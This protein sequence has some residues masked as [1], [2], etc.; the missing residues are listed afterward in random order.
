MPSPYGVG[1]AYVFAGA[2]SCLVAI[3]MTHIPFWLNGCHLLADTLSVKY[4]LTK[5][6]NMK[7][8]HLFGVLSCTWL[9]SLCVGC[10]NNYRESEKCDFYLAYEYAYK[11]QNIESVDGIPEIFGFDIKGD[12][13]DGQ[14]LV[15]KYA[16]GKKE[17]IDIKFLVTPYMVKNSQDIKA[18]LDYNTLSKLDKLTNNVVIISL[19]NG[20]SLHVDI[21]G[22]KCSYIV[23]GTIIEYPIDIRRLLLSAKDEMSNMP[24]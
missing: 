15:L 19:N 13:K 11:P 3:S 18:M 16:D 8:N 21:D 7:S 24:F 10:S 12:K 1:C 5:K 23:G 2:W 6:A 20:N 4:C 22:K 17:V 14:Q 9:L